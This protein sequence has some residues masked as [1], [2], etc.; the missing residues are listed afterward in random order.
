MSYGRHVDEKKNVEKF[1][2][3]KNK[4]KSEFV[5]NPLLDRIDSAIGFIQIHMTKNLKKLKRSSGM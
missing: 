3:K 5:E 4:R 1:I 2:E